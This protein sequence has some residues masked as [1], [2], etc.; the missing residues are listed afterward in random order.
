ME[1][2]EIDPVKLL[3]GWQLKEKIINLEKDIADAIKKIGDKAV[4]K[5]KMDKNDLSNKLKIPESKR[6]KFTG[7]DSSMVSPSVTILHEQR[8]ATH[9]DVN[10]SYDG[11]LTAHL[12]DGRLSGHS[13]YYPTASSVQLGSVGGPLPESVFGSTVAT[14]GGMLGGAIAGAGMSAGIGSATNGSYS[15]FYGDAVRDQAGTEINSNGQMYRW[16]GIGEAASIGQILVAQPASSRINSLYG[17]PPS[18][19]GFAGVPDHRSISVNKRS[20]RSDLYGFADAL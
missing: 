13:S 12:L 2:H 9:I 8:I 1:Y 20:G 7:R 19:E 16:P 4:V 10:S 3:P 17:L 14:G 6:S 18:V 15:G 5:R 11:S